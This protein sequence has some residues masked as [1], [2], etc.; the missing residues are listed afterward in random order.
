MKTICPDS[1]SAEDGAGARTSGVGVNGNG[2]GVIKLKSGVAICSDCAGGVYESGVEA[3]SVA[4]R[5]GVGDEAVMLHP[6]IK[7]KRMNVNKSLNL[8]VI[9]FD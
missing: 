8:S 2:V 1:W 9:Q 5:S 4:N 7:R 6:V 3:C